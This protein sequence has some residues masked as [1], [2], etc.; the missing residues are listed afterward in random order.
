M[1]D[2]AATAKPPAKPLTLRLAEWLV[3]W[4]IALLVAAATITACAYP[5]SR[6][7]ELDESIESFFAPG[8]PLLKGYLDSRDAFGGDE[9]VL[10]AY[11]RED[12]SSAESLQEIAEFANELSQVKGI[13]A[14]STQDLATTLRAS[15]AS[16]LNVLPRG[17]RLQAR[18]AIRARLVEF[19]EHLLIG[20]ND[21]VTAIILRL[22]P[23][24]EARIDR[25]KTYAEIR[26]LA[27]S[28][29]PPAFVA[30]EPIQVHEMFRYVERDG[31]VLGLA[32]TAL[33]VIAILM[34]F[35]RIRWV[36][37][38]L[39]IVQMT[40]IWTKA[41][42]YLAGLQL[43]MV[44]TMLTSLLTIIGVATVVHIIV[45]YRDQRRV[46]APEQA[47]CTTFFLAA[48]PVFWVTTTTVVGFAALLS[49]EITPIRS[50][51]WMMGI[52]TTL[53]LITFP[54]L[55]PAGVLLGKPEG[56]SALS[57]FEQ[58][59]AWV[60]NRMTDVTNA[61][62]WRTLIAAGVICLFAIQGCLM[63][64]IETDFSKNFRP[65]S[66]IVQSIR[67]FESK[68]GGVGSWEVNFE[69]PREL[70]TDYINRVRTLTD[71]L[72]NVATAD[73]T[74][75][76]K[77]VSMT[78][79]LDL[80]P[81][82]IADDWKIKRLWLNDLQ[83]EFEPSL[84][85]SDK[86]RMRIV[87]RAQEQQPAER[88]LELIRRVEEAARK[89]FPEAQT[90]GLYVLLASLISSVLGDQLSS[91]TW[92]ALGM[93][94]CVWIAFRNLRVALISLLPNIMPIL[95]VVGLIGWLGIPVNIGVAM[96]ASVSL[97]LTVDSSILYLTEY[98][99]V[100]KTGGT[101]D[102]AIHETHGGAA[103]AMVL[104]SVALI[105]GFAV[106][107]ASEF[108]P[109][110]FF[111]SMVS[112]AMLGGL[113]GNLVLLPV[114]LRWLPNDLAKKAPVATTDDVKAVEG[115]QAAV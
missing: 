97:G 74:K 38:P 81:P 92:S 93:I 72:R 115:E 70:T 76:T 71:D 86:Q 82:L 98:L 104:A 96:V 35:R 21:D 4:R 49:S 112:V 89:V 46:S 83:P 33:M 101:H 87:L 75:L 27:A 79:G 34:M 59:I 41:I 60:L 19:S 28:H 15:T 66:Q 36:I 48:S 24:M 29:N 69:A 109:L 23:E 2:T 61:H 105:A 7:V 8:D 1:A 56:P 37:L 64:R 5:L 12:I 39:A 102:R 40:L 103:L 54:L 13:N 26:R 100:R 18:R 106:L 32:S 110:A 9:F 17:L 73:G 94:A 50:F 99:G 51:A 113:L 65:T 95:F 30:G 31:R 45:L 16:V 63:Q 3:R 14:E 52:G 58:R 47:F 108:I 10:V 6:K 80:I 88:K 114:M 11:Q 84:Y 42:L 25:E 90:T 57:T 111:G 85:N 53:L 43:S 44:S 20:Q 77:V 22:V 91:A 68:L 67:F 107:T 55:L 62:P 78:D